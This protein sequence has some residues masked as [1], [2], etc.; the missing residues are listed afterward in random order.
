MQSKDIEDAIVYWANQHFGSNIYSCTEDLID[1][2]FFFSLLQSVGMDET[3]G[4]GEFEFSMGALESTLASIK[5]FYGNNENISE[6]TDYR[7]IVNSDII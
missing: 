1:G 6:H 5:E 2:D 4:D 7:D 3:K